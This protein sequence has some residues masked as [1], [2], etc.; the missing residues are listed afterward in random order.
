MI[1]SGGMFTHMTITNVCSHIREVEFDSQ[2]APSNAIVGVWKVG[3]VIVI[4]VTFSSRLWLRLWMADLL[5]CSFSLFD[6]DLSYDSLLPLKLGWSTVESPRFVVNY[7]RLL[8]VCRLVL[9]NCRST[10]VDK[11]HSQMK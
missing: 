4:W 5:L 8:T 6:S 1:Q 10:Y 3:L 9:M 2:H 11:K 7:R